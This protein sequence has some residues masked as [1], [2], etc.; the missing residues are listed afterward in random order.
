MVYK[1]MIHHNKI[2]F[3]PQNNSGCTLDIYK[4]N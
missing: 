4:C 3:I 1:T 2:K